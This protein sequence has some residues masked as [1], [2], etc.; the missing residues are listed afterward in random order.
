MDTK[1]VMLSIKEVRSMIY[2]CENKGCHYIF[3]GGNHETACPDCGK[4][5][6]REAVRIECTAFFRRKTE[7]L[8]EAKQPG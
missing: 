3:L 2:T 1:S 6:I 8:S 4:P 5:C 7:Y